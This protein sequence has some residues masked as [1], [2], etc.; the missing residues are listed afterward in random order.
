MADNTVQQPALASPPTTAQ[1]TSAAPWFLAAGNAAISLTSQNS[2]LNEQTNG[3]A[4]DLTNQ[5]STLAAAVAAIVT[6]LNA[7]PT[8]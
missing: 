8:A 7:K 4:A 2:A 5:N 1:G 6:A 3:V